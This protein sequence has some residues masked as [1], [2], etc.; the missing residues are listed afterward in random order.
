MI[1][2]DEV[3]YET[4]KEARDWYYVEYSPPFSEFPFS[5]LNLTIEQEAD[6]VKVAEAMESEAREW[7]SRFPVPVWVTAFAL[8]QDRIKLDGVRPNDHLMA[9][10]SENGTE[11]HWRLVENA[12][13]PTTAK[14]KVLVRQLFAG[15]PHR[16]GAEIRAGVL[17]HAKQMKAGWWLVF[18]W[19]VVVPLA[20]ALLEWWSDLLGLAVL[21]FAFINA[22]VKALRLTGKLPKSAREKEKEALDLR[23]RHHHYHCERNPEGFARLKAENFR[24]ELIERS[25]AE[26]AHVRKAGGTK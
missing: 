23:M 15:V 12:E 14:D 3:R 6:T 16:T 22:G 26:A 4:I 2:P 19:A 10:P 13:L 21:A 1:A 7:L 18:V 25:K 20:V 24:K 8:D 17:R 5:F 11:M 9:W